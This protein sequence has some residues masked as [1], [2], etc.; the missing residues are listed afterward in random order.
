[1][2]WLSGRKRRTRNA[3]GPQGSR[4]FKSHPHRRKFMINLF[5][6]SKK[7]LVNL[8]EV[9]TYL[10]KLDENVKEVT[11]N[12]ADFKK[13]SRKTIQKVS[14]IRFNPFN[15]SGGD[16]SFSLAVLDADNNG[17]IVTSL[18]GRDVNRVYAKP[19][20]DGTSSYSLSKE[21]KQ[22]LAKAMGS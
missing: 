4:E 16:Q 7:E 14:I 21:E 1:M 19:I 12:L 18:Y 10:K 20:K 5:K 9:L 3:V 13:A 11:Q 8:K 2:G 17:F 6:K 22:A 15:E